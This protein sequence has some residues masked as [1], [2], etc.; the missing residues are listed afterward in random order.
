MIGSLCCFVLICS[1][2]LERKTHFVVII[3]IM[4]ALLQSVVLGDYLKAINIYVLTSIFNFSYDF[5][6]L[7]QNQI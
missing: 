6:D 2:G 3:I 7:Q 5:N 1:H 4:I